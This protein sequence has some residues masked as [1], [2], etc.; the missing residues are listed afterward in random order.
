MGLIAIFAFG[1]A[2]QT[3]TFPSSGNAGVGT[4]TPTLQSGTTNTMV[5]VKGTVNPGVGLTSTATGGRQYF[6]YSSQTNPGYFSIFDATAGADRFVINNSGS[7]G[8]G[9]ATPGFG[10]ISSSNYLTLASSG[11]NRPAFEFVSNLPDG[12]GQEAG[13][14]EFVFNTNSAG[15]KRIGNIS[16]DTQG[17]TANQ[18]GGVMRFFTKPDAAATM[19]ERMRIDSVGNVG[20]GTSAPSFPL[21]V[22]KSQPSPTYFQVTNS[23]T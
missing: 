17:A 6:V 15:H 4:T 7:V 2:A 5:E 14:L 20:I 11:S 10:G 3:N 23:N 16:V 8:I 9:T 21:E 22:S 1:A 18:R 12:V 19:L 13:F